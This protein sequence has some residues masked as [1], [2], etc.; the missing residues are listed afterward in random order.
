M[1][2]EGTVKTTIT[3]N[4]ATITFFHPQKNSLPGILLQKFADEITHVSANK[5]VRV[6]IL[7]SESENVFCAGASFAELQAIHSPETGK[8]FFMGFANLILAMKKSP[9][10]ILTRVQGKAVGGGVGIIAASDYAIAHQSASIKLS[11]LALGLGPFVI[12]PAVERKVGAAAF[13]ALAL[14][15]DWRD[16]LWAKQHNLYTNVFENIVDVDK[17]IEKFS[18]KLSTNNPE[19]LAELKKVFWEGT[20]N[21]N[22]VLEKRAE[23]SGKLAMSEFTRNAIAAFKNG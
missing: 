21:W 3:K 4:I 2:Q 22:T 1:L 19:A 13:S 15:A 6:I 16:A 12:G 5:D 20:E 9:K 11:E 14:D 7:R 10:I 8:K 17:E 23:M 18:Q